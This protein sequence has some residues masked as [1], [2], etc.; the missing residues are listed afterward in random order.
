V[1]LSHYGEDSELLEARY[2]AI[3]VQSSCEFNGSK[4]CTRFLK[5]LM[6]Q[7]TLIDVMFET[8]ANSISQSARQAICLIFYP[9]FD[10]IALTGD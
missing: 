8:L 7:A 4:A 5:N 2:I 1:R 10:R 3:L 6:K 9:L